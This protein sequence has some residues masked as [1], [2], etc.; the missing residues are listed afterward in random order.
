M[1]TLQEDVY[2]VFSY[3][4]SLKILKTTWKGLDLDE[5]IFKEKMQSIAAVVPTHP[6][7]AFLAN[8][9]QFNFGIS[10]D[11]QEW[12][13]DLLFPVF[14]KAGLKKMAIIVS[15]DIFSQVSIEQAYDVNTFG[16]VTQY[17]ETEQEAT[18]WLSE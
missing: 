2:W 9:L 11:L 17:F 4:E 13:N 15:K 10:P 16:F 1:K 7:A 8:T 5:H 3:D 6:V 12:H 18:Q 14:E